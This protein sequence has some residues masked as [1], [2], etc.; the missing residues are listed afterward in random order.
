M[1]NTLLNTSQL[2]PIHINDISGSEQKLDTL[3]NISVEL[4]GDPARFV[5]SHAQISTFGTGYKV[6]DV[7]TLNNIAFVI[8]D[9]Y[10]YVSRL[11]P[12]DSEKTY[13]IDPAVDNVDVIGGSGTGMSAVIHT[14]YANGDNLLI[15]SLRCTPDS[16]PLIQR[17]G[18]IN[19]VKNNTYQKSLTGIPETDLSSEL[20][21]KLNS[22]NLEFSDWVL[23][24]NKPTYTA[25]EVG[26]LADSTTYA[27]SSTI[28]GDALSAD[29][30]NHKLTFLCNSNVIVETDGSSDTI[31]DITLA[32]LGGATSQ[33][34]ASMDNLIEQL[35]QND[36]I[37]KANSAYVKPDTGIVESD[38]SEELINIIKSGT[39]GT[40]IE[41]DPTVPMWAKEA[42]KP[43][44]TAEETGSLDITTKYA[45]SENIGG[46]AISANKVNSKFTINDI[47]FDG[48]ENISLT[49]SPLTIG[50]ATAVQGNLADT[51]SSNLSENDTI[52][53]ANTAYQKSEYGIPIIDFA[54]S[55]QNS[56][57]K[58]D[59][60]LQ[61][62]VEEDPIAMNKIASLLTEQGLI[63]QELLPDTSSFATNDQLV[64]IQDQLDDDLQTH[65]ETDGF[66]WQ[67]YFETVYKTI[68]LEVS[69]EGEKLDEANIRDIYVG[70]TGEHT[71]TTEYGGVICLDIITPSTILINGVSDQVFAGMPIGAKYRYYV[72]L[73]QG[74]VISANGVSGAT[75]TPIIADP[76]NPITI[77]NTQ[78]ATLQFGQVKIENELLDIRKSLQ[79]LILDTTNT[80]TV[81]DSDNAIDITSGGTFTVASALGGRLTGS[82][83]TILGLLGIKVGGT[84]KVS[85]NNVIVYDNTSLLSTTIPDLVIDV[86]NEDIITTTGMK[87]LVFTPYKTV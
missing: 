58:A 22:I 45:V 38:L 84:G 53:K 47:A 42:N 7:I 11:L 4:S 56:L 3:K 18:M 23:S 78:I 39:G 27:R 28:G 81:V 30:L 51:I 60:A 66:R 40:F 54:S 83:V 24:E 71:E 6:G 55:I 17:S 8:P 34:G 87:K 70:G 31:V 25:S 69:D 33:Q 15:G 57:N 75:I 76:L 13:T 73:K 50:A 72:R 48:S 68:Q 64:T 62:F 46:A 79:N 16:D 41:S 85:V 26:A 67:Q 82:G 14:R 43:T 19:Y 35:S 65:V 29:K 49:I 77:L 21:N 9:D 61:S 32:A 36:T 12:L 37:N 80:V 2:E 63:K 86:E 10:F 52:N 59:S 20:Q 5:I 44:Y 1:A 74:D